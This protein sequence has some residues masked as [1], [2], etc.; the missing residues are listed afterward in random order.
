MGHG[1]RHRHDNAKTKFGS[2][3]FATFWN[4]VIRGASF[5]GTDVHLDR[6]HAWRRIEIVH[7]AIMVHVHDDELAAIWIVLHA[8]LDT[9]VW[10]CIS[11]LDLDLDR[12]M[13]IKNGRK[14]HW[15]QFASWT[16]M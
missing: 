7:P 5:P 15:K 1:H 2:K 14:H 10:P 16:V 13:E 8:V 6:P 9:F 11:L 12:M 4:S 3:S